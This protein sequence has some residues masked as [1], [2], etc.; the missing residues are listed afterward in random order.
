MNLG[1]QPPK[2]ALSEVEGA[3]RQAARRL[4]HQAKAEEAA[5]PSA[6]GVQLIRGSCENFFCKP[7]AQ[8]PFWS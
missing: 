2:P 3:D 5:K 6:G 1:G 4:S 7:P 8:T